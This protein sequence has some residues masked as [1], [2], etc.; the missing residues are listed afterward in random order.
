VWD[1]GEPVRCPTSH[2]MDNLPVGP[3]MTEAEV[4]WLDEV[5]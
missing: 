3:D 4:A 1:D 2:D 5:A